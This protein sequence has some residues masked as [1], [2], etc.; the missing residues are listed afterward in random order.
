MAR[1]G[2]KG[3]GDD[4]AGAAS[5]A[6]GK[7]ASATGELA[8]GARSFLAGLAGNIADQVAA[9]GGTGRGGGT[10]KLAE[11]RARVSGKSVRTEQ[12]AV[13]RA[14]KTGK[15]P[16]KQKPEVAKAGADAARA[17][18]VRKASRVSVP[19]RVPVYYRTTKKGGG[20]EYQGMRNIG[21]QSN[22]TQRQFDAIAEA[23]EAG[24]EDLANDLINEAIF[25]SYGAGSALELEDLSGIEFE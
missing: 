14:L 22:I 3:T 9:L 10:R 7:T 15:A 20:R 2:S 16:A 23:I 18:K 11:A 13:Q 6:A 21:T 17:A 24:D 8:G 4:A 19:G 5:Q 25:M 1:K 12:R